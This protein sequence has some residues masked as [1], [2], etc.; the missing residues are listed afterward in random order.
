MGVLVGAL[1]IS[2]ISYALW[3]T[4]KE[5]TSVNK[6]SSGCL[7]LEVTEG[8]NINI[9]NAYQTPD[10]EGL[11]QESYNF[12]INNN[13][14]HEE[15][16]EVNLDINKNNTLNEKNIRATLLYN[17]QKII[18]PNNLNNLL[19]RETTNKEYNTGKHLTTVRINANNSKQLNLKIWLDENTEYEQINNKTF[20]SKIEID[21]I[22]REN[23]LASDYVRI[24]SEENNQLAYDETS[25]NN[26][27]YIGK[28]PN[29]YVD[30]NNEKWRIIGVM[31]NVENDSGTK[32][33]KIKLIRDEALSGTYFLDYKQHGVG[34]STNDMGS[35][36]WSDSQL[37]MMLNPKDVVIENWQ[38]Q[39]TK[40]G[41][42]IDSDG[43]AK[44][45][46]NHVMFKK[47]GS[48]YNREKGYKPN[49]ANI[50]NF[51]EESIDFS[52]NGLTNESKN[53][54]A[55]SV[56]YLGGMTWTEHSK[57]TTAEWYKQEREKKV[58]GKSPTKWIGYIGLMYPSDYGYATSGGNLSNRNICLTKELY[59]WGLNDVLVNE[60]KWNYCR[61]NDYIYENIYQWVLSPRTDLSYAAMEIRKA[62]Y[63]NSVSAG[64]SG[65]TFKPVLY[66]KSN[67]LITSGDGSKDNPYRLAL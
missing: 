45:N 24:I 9:E 42:I 65:R 8:T 6:I 49:Q 47:V 31:N 61:E 1:I 40:K 55:K 16:V 52:N 23:I 63:I 20:E 7:K 41:Y 30:F 26:L 29:N 64:D 28:D 10:D 5:Q 53:L 54:I 32:E 12:T 17:N 46:N 33:S 2:G 60:D 18:E 36:D 13:C 48:Y 38:T 4:T 27:R 43:T 22:K 66:L 15:Y 21:S 11:K 34:S 58:Y 67:V 56:F 51:T 35:N 19:D 44:D 25:D 14:N 37:M 62:G 59:N 50:T 3:S 57:S 39:E